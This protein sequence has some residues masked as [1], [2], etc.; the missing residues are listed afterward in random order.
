MD[1]LNG[2]DR[3]RFDVLVD[4][5]VAPCVVVFLAQFDDVF[6]FPIL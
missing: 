5:S 4:Y 6:S 1:D 3:N 2:M